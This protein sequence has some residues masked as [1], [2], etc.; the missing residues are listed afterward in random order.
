MPSVIARPGMNWPKVESVA[1]EIDAHLR[2][3]RLHLGSGGVAG[4]S[5]GSRAGNVE[6]DG[7]QV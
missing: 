3:Y 7:A 2:R 1:G 6:T 4:Q 5:V